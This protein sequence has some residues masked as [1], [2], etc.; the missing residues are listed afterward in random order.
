MSESVY[1]SLSTLPAIAR[2]PPGQDSPMK[3][4]AVAD[5]RCNR[6]DEIGRRC[7]ASEAYSRSFRVP[8]QNPTVRFPPDSVEKL[9]PGCPEAHSD[10]S[11]IE[12]SFGP[13]CPCREFF[14]TIHPRSARSGLAGFGRNWPESRLV[15]P[16]RDNYG[17]DI[18]GYQE[19]RSGRRNTVATR[20][21]RSRPVSAPPRAPRRP[22]RRA[23][24][25]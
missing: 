2:P 1:R 22:E 3:G 20:A 9:P 24:T 13:S 17:A 21:A 12:K 11:R 23:R 10:W 4:L 19:E 25:A 6:L 7:L 14:N 18:S 5:V 8:P 16:E 15:G